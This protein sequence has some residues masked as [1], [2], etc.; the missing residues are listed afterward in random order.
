MLEKIDLTKK[1]SKEEYKK[2]MQ[3]LEER[4]STLEQ[5]IKLKKIPVLIIFEGWSASGKGTFIS[6]MLNNLD[7]RYFT[8]NSMSKDTEENTYRPYLWKYWIKTPKEGEISI[9]DKSY[10]RIFINKE[11]NLTD[12]ERKHF[13]YDINSFEKTLNDSG[14]VIIKF[15][16]DISKEEQLKRLK[17]LKNNKET[18]WRVSDKNFKQ[19][20]D[21]DKYTEMFDEMIFK[22]NTEQN[23]WHIIE[24]DDDKYATVKIFK[25]V[26]NS[27]EYEIA[28]REA[29]ENSQE[30]SSKFEEGQ[31]DVLSSVDLSKTI[32]DEDYKKELKK[33]QEKIRALG[34]LLYKKRKSV[35]IAYEG[36]DA[37]GKGGNIKRMTQMLD[38]RGYEVVPIAS[39][40]KEELSHN[41]LWRFWNKLPKDGHITIFDRTW[42]GRVMVERIE[43]FCKES[44]WQRAYKEINDFEYNITNHNTLLIKFWLHIDKDEQLKRFTDRQ[45]TP[46]KQYKITDEDWRNREKWDE[47]EKAVNEMLFRT[48][49]KYAP[50]VVVESN[51]KKYARIKALKYVVEQMESFL[52]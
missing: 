26:I 49:T 40:S 52:K 48:S 11:Y 9:F 28:K 33:Y 19:N 30:Y 16:I 41:Y 7:P 1:L 24:A 25:S 29:K 22:T 20:A 2:E 45:N 37:A 8:V 35:I 50:W 3:V 51:N 46:A 34:Y 38:P 4:L 17:K 31:V 43:G 42:Y 14:T 39:P 32:S 27:V 21:Y 13:F 36:W 47:Y 44:D 18:S 10:H 12:K 15:F 6:R 5:E 23:P